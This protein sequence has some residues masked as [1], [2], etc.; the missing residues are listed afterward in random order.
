MSIPTQRV[1]STEPQPVEMLR[2]TE[3]ISISFQMKKLQRYS[4][5]M[6]TLT[7]L[8]RSKNQTWLLTR[9]SVSSQ[10]SHQEEMV[11][12]QSRLYLNV[13]G[14]LQDSS[15]RILTDNLA[16]KSNSRLQTTY[17]LHWQLYWC[18]RWISS[19]D[20]S[21]E[22]EEPWKIL[23]KPFMESCSCQVILI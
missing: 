5:S 19:I 18:K 1:E 9:S 21:T 11:S 12:H 14:I 16:K 23:K 17:C 4:D 2:A 22:W 6:T 15:Q 8:T 20:C 3:T 10:E 13:L 7:F